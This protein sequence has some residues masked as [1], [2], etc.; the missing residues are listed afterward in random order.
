MFTKKNRPVHFVAPT[1]PL[2][3]AFHFVY[4]VATSF[5]FFFVFQFE[6]TLGNV[7]AYIVWTL[8]FSAVLGF[9]LT[10]GAYEGNPFF[11][12]YFGLAAV[13]FI[14]LTNYFSSAYYLK[15]VPLGTTVENVDNVI[16]SAVQ[17]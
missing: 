16:E 14:A 2:I 6:T 11:Y 3:H 4:V 5:L 17:R 9:M 8:V 15:A 12:K 13:V 1:G 7:L 10:G